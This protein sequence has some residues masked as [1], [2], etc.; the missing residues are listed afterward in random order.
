MNTTKDR[1]EIYEELVDCYDD[2]ST[3]GEIALQTVLDNIE[4]EDLSP[5]APDEEIEK[6]ID[7]C[8]ENWIDDIRGYIHRRKKTMIGHIREY[9]E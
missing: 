4:D 2:D 8:I 3:I 5:D 7:I 1:D 6:G 9:L